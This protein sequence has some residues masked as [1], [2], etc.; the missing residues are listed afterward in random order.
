MTK[1]ESLSDMVKTSL[2]NM[3]ENGMIICEDG[4]YSLSRRFIAI[5]RKR[6]LD[7]DDIE[8]AMVN[9][10]DIRK[11]FTKSIVAGIVVE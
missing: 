3:E 7:D 11:N 10:P 5:M 9:M 1:E 8:F 2:V 4:G 6:G